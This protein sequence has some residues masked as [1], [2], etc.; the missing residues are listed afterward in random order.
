M[1]VGEADSESAVCPIDFST[2]LPSSRARKHTGADFLLGNRPECDIP[3]IIRKVSDAAIV[4]DPGQSL[5]FANR[6]SQSRLAILTNA[7]I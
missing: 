4:A 7:F 6:P 1:E 5:R 2:E 3:G